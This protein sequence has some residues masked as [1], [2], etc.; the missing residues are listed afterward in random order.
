MY[1]TFTFG[2]QHQLIYMYMCVQLV[3]LMTCNI[4]FNAHTVTGRCPRSFYP[5][6]YQ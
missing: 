5:Y 2:L 6:S 1:Y 4:L 3:V